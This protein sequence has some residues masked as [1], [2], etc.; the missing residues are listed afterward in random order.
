MKNHV[1][2]KEDYLTI[3]SQFKLALKN[4]ENMPYHNTYGTK[5]AGNFSL[6]SF[7]FYAILRGK[8]HTKCTHDINSEKY[9]TLISKLK[10]GSY[11]KSYEY[12]KFLSAIPLLND[13]K[14]LFEIIIES[15]IE[16]L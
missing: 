13:K 15:N 14:E 10:D 2:S 5:F 3:V 6:L 11:K 1:I 9:T 12:R 8:D 7:V 4:K 16:K